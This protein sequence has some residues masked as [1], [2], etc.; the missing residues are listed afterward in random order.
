[1]AKECCTKAEN[2]RLC[3]DS[4]SGSTVKEC[5]VCASRHYGITPGTAS[6]E[7]KGR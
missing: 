3:L 4:K 7:A 1:M 5:K 6:G 2:L